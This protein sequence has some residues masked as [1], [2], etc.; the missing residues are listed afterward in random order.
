MPEKT[1]QD[2]LKEKLLNGSIT[3]KDFLLEVLTLDQ[4]TDVTLGTRPHAKANSELLRDTEVQKI[5]DKQ[6]QLK[7]FLE[8][9][10]KM[11]NQHAPIRYTGYPN[12]PYGSYGA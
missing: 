1:I 9:L 12:D 7:D 5:F 3:E 4:E 6:P 10:Q 2:E 11:V 8:E